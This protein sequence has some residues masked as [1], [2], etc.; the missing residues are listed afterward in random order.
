MTKF[1][2][3]GLP[4]NISTERSTPLA[5]PKKK[6]T[7]WKRNC[8]TEMDWY[9]EGRTNGRLVPRCRLPFEEIR[10]LKTLDK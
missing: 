3:P 6:T 8:P 2:L 4:C 7:T 10:N 5:P 9:G 1:I